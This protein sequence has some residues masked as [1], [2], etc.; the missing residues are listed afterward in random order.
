M[1][2]MCGY[3][4]MMGNAITCA[5]MQLLAIVLMVF[6]SAA[7]YLWF[8]SVPTMMAIQLLEFFCY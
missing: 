5:M 8:W 7:W 1:L 4:A 2:L 6:P 3:R